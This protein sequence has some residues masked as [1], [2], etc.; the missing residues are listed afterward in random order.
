MTKKL[1]GFAAVA[2]MAATS[3]MIGLP[4]T[5]GAITI[6]GTHGDRPGLHRGGSWFEREDLTGGPADTTFNYG[7]AGDFPLMCDFDGNGV[8]TPTVV[9]GN[10]WFGSDSPDASTADENFFLGNGFGAGDF[11][12]CGDM[13]G[14]QQDDP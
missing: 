12:L 8:R 6:Q 7:D 1:M 10:H 2:V 5:A 11:P 13:N 3:I 14:D 4:G 9:R